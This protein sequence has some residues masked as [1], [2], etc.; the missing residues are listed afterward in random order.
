MSQLEAALKKV[1]RKA[2]EGVRD[3][4]TYAHARTTMPGDALANQVFDAQM[5]SGIS[6]CQ[7]CSECTS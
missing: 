7:Q 3:M 2:D 1:D 6:A 5:C 4:L